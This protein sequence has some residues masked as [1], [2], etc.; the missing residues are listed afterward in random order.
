MVSNKSK[1][2]PEKR[3]ILNDIPGVETKPLV[4]TAGVF[5]GKNYIALRRDNALTTVYTVV[6]YRG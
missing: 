2:G 1:A 6:E 3:E 5:V 4:T